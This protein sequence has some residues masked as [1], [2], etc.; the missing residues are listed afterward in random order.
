LSTRDVRRLLVDEGLIGPSGDVSVSRWSNG[1]GDVYAAH[2][3]GYDKVLLVESGSIRFDLPE[4]GRS[5]ELDG[6]NRLDLP[7]GTLH[8][9]T[10][11]G[12]G[13]ACLEA[14]L[15]AGALPPETATAPR[16]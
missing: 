6:G 9:A 4:L 3:H 11:G 14:H 16:A 2:R 8:A 1:P 15:P 5:V 13:V 12:R 7:A 10:V